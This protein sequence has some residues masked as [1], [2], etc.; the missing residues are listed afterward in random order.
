MATR[1]CN[2]GVGKAWSADGRAT[3]RFEITGA[4]VFRQRKETDAVTDLVEQGPGGA[5]L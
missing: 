1:R 4:V 3:V 5:R 2:R